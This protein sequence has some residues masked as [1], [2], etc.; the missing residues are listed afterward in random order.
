MEAGGDGSVQLWEVERGRDV[1]NGLHIRQSSSTLQNQLLHLVRPLHYV[2]QDPPK[3]FASFESVET[4][5]VINL[6]KFIK[7]QLKH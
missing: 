4:K 6:G 2:A 5:W 7:L 1:P 3:F